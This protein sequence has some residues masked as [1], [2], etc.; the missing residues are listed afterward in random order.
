[1]K[2]ASKAMQRRAKTI[3]Y[4]TYFIGNG[5]DM[6]C[7]ND[8]IIEFKDRFNINSVLAYDKAQ[9]NAELCTNVI[10]NRFDFLHSSHCLEHLENPTRGLLNWIRL[11]KVD[12]YLIITV[13]DEEMYEKNQWPSIMNIQHHYSFRHG[14]DNIRDTSIDVT[15]WFS[16]FIDVKVISIKRITNDYYDSPEDLTKG[17]AECAIEIVLQ[18]IAHSYKQ[19]SRWSLNPF[20]F[21]LNSLALGDVIAAVPTIKYMIDNYYTDPSTYMVVAKEMFKPLFS[22]VPDKNFRSFEDNKANWGIPPGWAIGA[23]NQKIQAGTGIVRNTPKSI[24]LGQFA[25]LKLVDKLLD[26]ELLNYIPLPKVDITKFGIDFNKAVIIVSSYRDLTRMWKSDYILEVASWLRLMDKTPVFIG[27]TDMNMDT[28]LIPK[29][30]LP[31]D[32]SEYGVDLRNK[33]SILEL[34]SIMAESLAVIGLDSGPIHLAGTTSVPIICGYTSVDP[35]YRTPI[36][37]KGITIPIAANIPCNHCESNW[38]GNFWN[39][40]E[41]F[42]SS[43]ECCEHMTADKFIN[44]LKGVINVP[45]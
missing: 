23:I 17:P 35:I 5:I 27:K 19:V 11:V 3:E 9:G 41:C 40:E 13:P 29:T 39:Y 43:N 31:N 30:S 38:A 14:G 21:M 26:K 36:R 20:C 42:L 1:M 2:E 45:A 34:A 32:V 6:G 25:A 28:H 44:A 4:D 10:D 33:T 12:G 18:K 7:G 24:H 37:L 22:F 15:T 8:N 16:R